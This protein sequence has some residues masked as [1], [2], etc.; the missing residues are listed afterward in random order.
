MLEKSGHRPTK[1]KKIVNS[2]VLL[3]EAKAEA[4][5]KIAASTFLIKIIIAFCDHYHKLFLRKIN[6]V[7]NKTRQFGSFSIF[8]AFQ[9]LC[10]LLFGA[11]LEYKYW[12]TPGFS[13]VD[14]LPQ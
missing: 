11:Q 4:I 1:V 12:E 2:R 10:F 14:L 3:V 9:I 13:S 8:A 5:D 7:T 6:V